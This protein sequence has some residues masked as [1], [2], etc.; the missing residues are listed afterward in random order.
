M[1]TVKPLT[2]QAIRNSLQSVNKFTK[3]GDGAKVWLPLLWCRF[4]SMNVKKLRGNSHFTESD[5]RKGR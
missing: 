1:V 5:G 4:F 2:K 3:I